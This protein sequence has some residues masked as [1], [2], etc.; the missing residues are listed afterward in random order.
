MK[1]RPAAKMRR[2]NGASRPVFQLSGLGKREY[3]SF[4]FPLVAICACV[5]VFLPLMAKPLRA[6][7]SEGDADHVAQPAM[8]NI[9]DKIWQ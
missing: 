7:T 8:R 2:T 5:T 4:I 1:N 3:R 6:Q 9:G